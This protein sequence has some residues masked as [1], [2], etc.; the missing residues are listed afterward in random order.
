MAFYY[1]LK[2]T[3]TEYLLL[4]KVFICIIY[5]ILTAFVAK[6]ARV[7]GMLGNAH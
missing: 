7:A 3:E 4:I 5:N 1:W 6:G 2:Y